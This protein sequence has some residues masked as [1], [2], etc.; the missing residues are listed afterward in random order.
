MKEISNP[1]K[2][3]RGSDDKSLQWYRSQI[4]KLGVGRGMDPQQAMRAGIGHKVN[5]IT[6]GKMYL[7]MY[8]AKWKDK[9]PYWDR[10]PLVFPYE[11]TEN[12]FMGINFHYLPHLL[13]VKLLDQ[14]TPY[15]TAQKRM[16]ET[17]RLRLS[18]QVLKQ[19]SAVTP[20]VKRYLT[21]H[22]MTSFI[23][24]HPQDWKTA[25]LL[26]F[27]TFVGKSKETVFRDSKRAINAI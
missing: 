11:P 24:I 6:V 16:T 7:Y 1:L 15:A 2:P 4:Q 23:E 13:R 10:F 26:P 17:T 27:E 14:L 20:C 21:S 25:V 12:G 18:W 9:L 3:L 8:D 22:V 5:R 19:Y